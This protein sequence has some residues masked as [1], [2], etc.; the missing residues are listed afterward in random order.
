MRVNGE[1]LKNDLKASWMSPK[2]SKGYKGLGMEGFI[3]KWYAK[4]T[5]K[6]MEEFKI[7]ARRVA[8]NMAEGSSVLELA[9]GP[10]Y[11]AIE[12]VRLG[13]HRIVGLD[14]SKTFVDIAQKKAKEVGVT[15]EFRQGDAAH[16]PFDNETFDF[17]ICRAVFKNFAEPIR[18]L[19][20]MHRVLKLNGKSL[21]ID[22]RRD[23]PRE[24]IDKYVEN[25]GLN[26]INSLITTWTFRFMLIKRAY[27]KDE[28]YRLVSNTEFRK[29][30]IQ[31]SLTGL[32]IWLEK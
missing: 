22:L 2:V 30:E 26:R 3:A 18:A 4:I 28:F 8:E 1:M 16:M 13:N 29:C 6:D 25:M 7:L 12:L 24:S 27:T 17:I 20:E 5:Q 14:I 9:P 23:V 10:G 15:I 11:L 31:E 21:I 19:N 32:E